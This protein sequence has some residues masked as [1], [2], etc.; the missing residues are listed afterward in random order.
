MAR[1]KI[2][3]HIRFHDFRHTF[4]NHL[5]MRG[6]DLRTVAK[7]MGHKDIKMTMRYAHLAPDHLQAAVDVA[8]AE[9]S[10]G[11]QRGSP[12]A[13]RLMDRVS[14]KSPSICS[15]GLMVI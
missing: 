5:V 7:L 3:K 2:E 15:I 6:I 9:V 1:S 12:A 10:R 11:R 8:D 14:I 13:R 4:A